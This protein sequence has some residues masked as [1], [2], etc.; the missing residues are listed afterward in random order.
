MWNPIFRFIG[1][2]LA[3]LALTSL[4]VLTHS[5]GTNWV[6]RYF[7][8]FHLYMKDPRV[9]KAYYV[10]M[11]G[12]VA[13]MVATHAIEVLIWILFYL[14]RCSVPD[15]MSAMFFSIASYTTLGSS[16]ITLPPQWR[17]PQC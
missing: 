10:I 14:L 11:T 7:D 15:A 13:I 12:I 8:T 2:F 4:T 6:R 9:F 16:N 17:W 3:A 5:V 1:Q